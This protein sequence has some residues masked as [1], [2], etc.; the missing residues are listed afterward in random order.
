MQINSTASYLTR[1][2]LCITS[3]NFKKS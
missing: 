1:S 3:H 2:A